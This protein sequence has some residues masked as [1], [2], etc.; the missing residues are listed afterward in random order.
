[1][2]VGRLDQEKKVLHFMKTSVRNQRALHTLAGRL[3]ELLRES[4]P[5]EMV[6]DMIGSFEQQLDGLGES[7]STQE[8][9][10]GL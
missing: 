8:K 4:N 6:V 1:M 9:L 7:I 3:L 5:D 2:Q 10:L